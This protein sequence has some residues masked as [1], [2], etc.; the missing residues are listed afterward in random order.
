MFSKLSLERGFQT[1][2]EKWLDIFHPGFLAPVGYY[3]SLILFKLGQGPGRAKVKQLLPKR[4]MCVSVGGRVKREVRTKGKRLWEHITKRTYGLDFLLYTAAQVCVCWDKRG[5]GRS[6]VN[7]LAD[8]ASCC[9]YTCLLVWVKLWSCALYSPVYVIVATF[10]FWKPADWQHSVIGWLTQVGEQFY[11]SF[12]LFL[13][14]TLSFILVVRCLPFLKFS[15]LLSVCHLC[16]LSTVPRLSVLHLPFISFLPPPS[17]SPCWRNVAMYSHCK[18]A[19]L[20]LT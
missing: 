4:H 16:H 18:T 20:W 8:L 17:A 14:V 15:F 11:F 1:S 3:R 19:V 6:T 7:N 13:A 10:H 9:S 2:G 5:G 12:H